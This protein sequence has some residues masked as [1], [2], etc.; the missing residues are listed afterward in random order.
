MV[1]DSAEPFY[2]R[3]AHDLPMSQKTD[4]QKTVFLKFVSRGV[5]QYIL[6]AFLESS[7]AILAHI[8]VV[9]CKSTH[10]TL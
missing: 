4:F 8:L 2:T 10:I 3:L 7:P 5:V 1:C 9:R 6:A